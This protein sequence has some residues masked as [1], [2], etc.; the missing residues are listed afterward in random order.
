MDLGAT[1]ANLALVDP[2]KADQERDF[3]LTDILR[4]RQRPLLLIIDAQGDLVYSSSPEEGPDVR[5]GAKPM[6]LGLR[7]QALAEAQ[8]LLQAEINTIAVAQ[9]RLVID[10][11]GE[12]CAL[13]VLDEQFFC[14][15]LFNLESH[16][17]GGACLF[18][19]LL[20]LIG[21]PETGGIDLERVKDLFRLSNREADVVEALLTGGTDKEIARSLGVSVE[22][23]RAYLKSVRAK[24]G[25]S[26]RTAIVSL[27]HGVRN[28]KLASK[29]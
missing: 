26:T 8:H 28:D 15:R 14:L 9:E 6:T 24:L 20:E 7:K 23:I 13:V 1:N 16:G 11:P 29:N 18:A 12:R 21:D 4:K 2:C 17:S 19:V 10:K 22:T 27:V 5:P 3:K 25:V